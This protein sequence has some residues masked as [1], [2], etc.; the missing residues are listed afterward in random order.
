MDEDDKEI[1][2]TVI[3]TSEEASND[4]KLLAV[5]TEENRFLRRELQKSSNVRQ[6]LV[7]IMLDLKKSAQ[8]LNQ[9]IQSINTESKALEERIDALQI[10]LN[11]K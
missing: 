10:Q 6:A 9:Q 2:F 1:K 8:Q 11:K 4:N 3:D 5:L 7:L